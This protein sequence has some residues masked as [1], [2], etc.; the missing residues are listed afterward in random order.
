MILVVSNMYPSK[1]YPNYG[2]FVKNF[3]EQLSLS[4]KANIIYIQKTTNKVQKLI[5]YLKF[6]SKIFRQ[7]VF[8]KYEVVYV[9]YAGYN[10][11]PI[12][13]AKMFNKSTKLIVNV[14]GSDVTPEKKLEEK[15]N[16]LTK[17][18][19]RKANLTV[20]P[21]SYF[22][23]VVIEKYGRHS[24]IWISPSAGIDLSLFNH[25]NKKIENEIFTI[26]YVS[27]IDKEKGWDTLLN[28]F[29]SLIQ[30]TNKEIRLIMVGDGA[31]NEE[32]LTLIKE[33]GLETYVEKYNCL[34]QKELVDIY[35][36]LDVFIFPSTR[37][38]ESLG[39]VGLEAMACG[40]PVIGSNLGGIKTYIKD[41]KN[42][43]LI[44]PGNQK[45]LET[46]IVNYRNLTVEEKKKFSQHAIETAK[47]YDSRKV[48]QQLIEK[49]KEISEKR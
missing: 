32:A 11:P 27:R 7:Y 48:N 40:T 31:Q 29:K 2:I 16:F 49:I 4:E 37:A 42:G 43:F 28:A 46:A 1:K 10:A 9:H 20:V 8:G 6:Y 26:G 21:S 38:G 44:A 5:N 3:Y 39:L 24:P 36:R 25:Q 41:G 33:L 15:T 19:V 18:L 12:L 13:L 45:E 17:Y 35:S 23:E 14:H 47:K 30:H 22:E 34:P